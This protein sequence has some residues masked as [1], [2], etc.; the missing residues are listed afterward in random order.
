[1]NLR[2]LKKLSKRA[3]PYL[4]ILGDNRQQFPAV[5][6]ENYHHGFI[7]DRKHWER[8]RC[9]PSYEARNSWTS[10]R[11]AEIVR[12]TRSGR[13]IVIRPP[14]HP[15]KGTIMVGATTGYFEPEWDE[16][17][18]WSALENIVRDHFTDWDSLI[19]DTEDGKSDE[20]PA[21]GYLTRDLSTVSQ[22]FRAADEMVARKPN[23]GAE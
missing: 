8:G 7:G 15:R 2:T 10:A 5:G 18:A 17:C 13:T 16:Q 6:D 4:P 12:K 14:V 11:G 22:I 20:A 9:H 23:G 21:G 19:R 1:M 3:A